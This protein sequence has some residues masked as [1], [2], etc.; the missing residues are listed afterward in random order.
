[1]KRVFFLSVSCALAMGLYAQ[2]LEFYHGSTL[3]E[4]DATIVENNPVFE[5]GMYAFE[6]DLYLV[7]K[8]GGSANLTVRG[9]ADL[10]F[11]ACCGGTCMANNG[12]DTLT[13][14]DVQL[15]AGE[16]VPLQFEWMLFGDESTVIPTD[17]VFE[18]EAVKAYSGD[19]VRM[20]VICNPSGQDG[21]E[22]VTESQG[23]KALSSGLL[24]NLDGECRVQVYSMSGVQVLEAS[25]SGAGLLST[26]ALGTGV[27]LYTVS[28]ATD[29]RG[30]ILVR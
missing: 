24:Y 29:C 13:K 12:S 14:K 30:R 20:T 25:V 22:S 17:K 26:S 27:Y 2:D 18:L 16:K 10:M 7:S 8:T 4:G 15:A 28:G 6:P 9:D 1:M 23:V 3:L 21:V 11:Q 5:Y 19:T